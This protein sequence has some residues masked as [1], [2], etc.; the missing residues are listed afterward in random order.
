MLFLMDL[1]E[2]KNT[3][4]RPTISHGTTWLSIIIPHVNK[5]QLVSTFTRKDKSLLHSVLTVKK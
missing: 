1:Q 5:Q 4:M 2:I 3:F